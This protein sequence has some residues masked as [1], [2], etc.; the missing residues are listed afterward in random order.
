M[1][2]NNRKKLPK[3]PV[4][5]ILVNQET[6]S[7]LAAIVENADKEAIKDGIY[8]GKY[9]DTSSGKDRYLVRE[10][11]RDIY[12]K[13][14]AYCEDIDAKPEVEHYRPKKKVSEDDS[15]P[16]YYWLCYEWT[17]LL[18]SCHYCNTESGKRD[19]F[20]IKG[21]R[22]TVPP[23]NADNSWNKSANDAAAS[24]LI[25]EQPYLLHPEIDQPDDGSFFKFYDNGDIEGIDH[26]GRGRKTIDICDLRRQNLLLRRQKLVIDPILK[27]ILSV[28][29]LWA[30]GRFINNNAFKETL[31]EVFMEIAL[32]QRA[33]QPF[34]LLAKYIYDHFDE[35][36]IPVIKKHK[37]LQKFPTIGDSVAAAFANFKVRLKQ[38]QKYRQN[39]ID[40]SRD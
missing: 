18:P 10:R 12:Y 39:I 5:E 35:I 7:A 2:R 9:R 16:G 29:A 14:C 13:K 6:N 31:S 15:H 8:K 33:D 3:F 20:P 36:I 28:L 23:L 27:S 26:H 4:P 1:R 40:L 30:K 17:N 11:L 19:Q 34:S 21:K 25:D 24:P 32:R 22:V 38:Q 37:D